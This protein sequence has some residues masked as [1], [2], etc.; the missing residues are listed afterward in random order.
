MCPFREV[1]TK[2]GPYGFVDKLILSTQGNDDTFRWLEREPSNILGQSENRREHFK[3]PQSLKR[4][5]QAIGARPEN[6]LPIFLEDS[7]KPC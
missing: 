6:A 4:R 1:V 2:P 7:V 3:D 5:T